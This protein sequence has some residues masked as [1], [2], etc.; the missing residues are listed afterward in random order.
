MENETAHRKRNSAENVEKKR[1]RC[2]QRIRRGQVP[3]VSGNIEI[4]LVNQLAGAVVLKKFIKK[5]VKRV[6]GEGVLFFRVIG[7]SWLKN[8]KT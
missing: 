5:E 2:P 3:E 4:R 7:T 6:G 8:K 1:I